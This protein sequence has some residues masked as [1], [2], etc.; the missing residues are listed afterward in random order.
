M[1][2]SLALEPNY[3]GGNWGMDGFDGLAPDVSLRLVPTSNS[4]HYKSRTLQSHSCPG[5]F[6]YLLYV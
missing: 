4:L 2:G 6:L 5:L 1:A 3:F